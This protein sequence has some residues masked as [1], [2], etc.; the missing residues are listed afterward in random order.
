MGLMKAAKKQ[1]DEGIRERK[2]IKKQI[3]LCCYYYYS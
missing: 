1:W 2:S 3:L